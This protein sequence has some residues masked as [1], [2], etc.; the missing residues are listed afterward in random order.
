VIVTIRTT[1]GEEHTRQVDYPRGDPRNPLTDREVEEKFESLAKPVLSPDSMLR[2][3]EAV[4]ELEKLQ[5]ISSLMGLLR[6]E[7]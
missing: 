3:K 5:E 4:W 7:G 6:A 1:S 2:V